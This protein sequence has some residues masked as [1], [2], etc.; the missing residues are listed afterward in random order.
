MVARENFTLEYWRGGEF[1]AGRC[2]EVPV[3]FGQEMTLE[4]LQ[5][6]IQDACDLM[7]GQA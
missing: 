1:Y 2:L 6:N 3:V 5:E 4:G 7:V